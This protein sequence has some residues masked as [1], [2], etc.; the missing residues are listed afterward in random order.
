M[1]INR[2]IDWE[3]VAQGVTIAAQWKQIWLVPMKMGFN[4]CLHSVAQQSGV[5]V[6]CSIGHKCGSDPSLLWQWY[7]L[8]AGAPIWLLAWELPY[9][10]GVALKNQK[11]KKKEAVHIYNG[12]LLSHKKE[13][14]MLFAVTCLKLK[15]LML[16]DINQKEKDKYH[17]ISLI[18]GI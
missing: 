1:S 7:M 12:I 18:C 3:D 11:K 14:W 6:S 8:A 10:S 13:N 2:W 17:M 15:I 5:A 16:S 4:P 9:A